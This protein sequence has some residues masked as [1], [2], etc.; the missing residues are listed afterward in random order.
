MSD[1]DGSVGE[2]G[3]GSFAGSNR[4]NESESKNS[5]DDDS[6][7]MCEV[8][9]TRQTTPRKKRGGFTPDNEDEAEAVVEPRRSPRFKRVG[10]D[11][12]M[13]PLRG[14]LNC[15]NSGGDPETSESDNEDALRK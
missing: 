14:K 6:E 4:G 8:T 2:S 5:S 12:S 10:R 11:S 13:P 1:D 9:G 3:R 7:Q 15:R